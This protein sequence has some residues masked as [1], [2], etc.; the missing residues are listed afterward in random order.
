MKCRLEEV[1]RQAA[2]CEVEGCDP[3][4]ANRRRAGNGARSG[5]VG[6]VPI[7]TSGWQWSRRAQQGCRR[8]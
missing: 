7:F 1:K 4:V 6:R 2:A 8:G 3:D 5:H